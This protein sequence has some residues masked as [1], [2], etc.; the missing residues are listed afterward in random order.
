[1]FI[2]NGLTAQIRSEY[3]QI[4]NEYNTYENF[5]SILQFENVTTPVSIVWRW[6]DPSGA[7][8]KESSQKINKGRT[9]AYE[10]FLILKGKPTDT[11]GIWRVD[12][13]FDDIVVDSKSFTLNKPVIPINNFP[14][15][16]T[17]NNQQSYSSGCGP[18]PAGYIGPDSNCKCINPSCGCVKYS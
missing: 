6:V 3:T 8:Y 5:Y 12:I 1:M 10:D 13:L 15:I 14:I 9:W 17:S 7:L 4:S 11:P 16:K 2:L 18:C